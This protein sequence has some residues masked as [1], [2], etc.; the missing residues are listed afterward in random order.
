[1]E[2]KI[3]QNAKIN[4][5]GETTFEIQM[6]TMSGLQIETDKG[7]IT[8]LIEEGQQCCEGY[9]SLFLETPDNL[10]KFIGAKIIKIEDVC[11]TSAFDSLDWEVEDGEGAYETQLKIT[12]TK[13]VL[14]YAVYNA[15][16]GYYCHATFL[17]VFEK[18]EEDYL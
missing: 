4:K 16:N 1:M 14:Q 2:Y 15:H 7:D 18:I 12:T 6:N 9:D 8:L 17:Q 5:I 3:P 13:G 10:G 11:V